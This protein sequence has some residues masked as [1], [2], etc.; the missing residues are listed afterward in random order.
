MR[1]WRYGALPFLPMR[2]LLHGHAPSAGCALLAGCTNTDR[3]E[4]DPLA[5]FDDGSCSASSVR[6]CTSSGATNFN[7]LAQVDD[8]SCL[9]LGCTNS[10]SILYD[11]RA[12]RDDGSCPLRCAH[13]SCK[14]E[15]HGRRAPKLGQGPLL[16]EQVW[17]FTFACSQVWLHKPSCRKF[18]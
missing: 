12:S 18:R 6:G 3:P 7:I 10:E 14:K 8:G 16:L 11:S 15:H 1:L 5:T 2:T 4:Y 9:L 13:V 17:S